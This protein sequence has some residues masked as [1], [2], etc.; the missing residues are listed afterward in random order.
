METVHDVMQVCRNGHVITDRLLSDPASGRHHCDRC[1]ASTLYRCPTCSGELLG[2]NCVPDM[3]PIGVWPAPHFCLTCGAAFPWV[4]KPQP[5]PEPLVILEVFL[6]RLPRVIHELRWRQG[7][8]PPYRVENE[9]DLEDLLRSV[10]PLHFDD[11][12]LESRLPAY[13]SGNR[14]DLLLAKERIAITVKF[15]RSGFDEKDMAQKWKEDMAYYRGRDRWRTLVGYIYDPEG[16]IRD[17]QAMEALMSERSDGLDS[18]G[19][20][21]T[22]PQE[23][24][25]GS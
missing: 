14:T 19:I 23:Q 18:L 7:T 25:R 3:V 6:R 11:I 13:S 24:S 15:V 8:L 22:W 2:A 9:R 1:G 4:R 5:T 20:V 10:L 17:A 16:S 21:G 12:R